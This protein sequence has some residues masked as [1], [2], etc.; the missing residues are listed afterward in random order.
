MAKILTLP[1]LSVVM[2]EGT[3]I[4]WYFKEGDLIKKGDILFSYYGYGLT[5]LC[6]V[7]DVHQNFKQNTL[8]F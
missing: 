7:A 5:A 4:N 3:V 1:K 6:F 2:K 8:F